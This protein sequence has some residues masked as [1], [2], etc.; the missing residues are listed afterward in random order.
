MGNT[1][2]FITEKPSV[3]QEYRKVLNVQTKGK[4][5]GY[6]EGFSQFINANVI[7]TWAIG[8][9]IGIAP[10]FVQNPAWKE[11]N[12]KNLPMIPEHFKYIPIESTAKQLKIVSS[13]YK[14]DDLSA[15]YYAGDS[16]REGIYI[17]ALIRNY[18]FGG[19]PKNITER[20]VWIDSFT[21]S[22]IKRG[23]TQA[24]P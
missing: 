5:D 4:T 6:I 22:E 3:A 19:T 7:I 11:W 20:V 2:L 15:I 13:L 9:L 10:P 8:H 18:I 21:E 24:K 12:T 23:I 14:R 16:G 1:T 17:Q